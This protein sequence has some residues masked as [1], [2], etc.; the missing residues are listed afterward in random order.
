MLDKRPQGQTHLNND[1]DIAL[2]LDCN[3]FSRKKSIK[4]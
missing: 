2:F 1:F 4:P 3:T